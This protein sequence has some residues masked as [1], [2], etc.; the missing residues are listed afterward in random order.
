MLWS[1]PGMM[2]SQSEPL[3]VQRMPWSMAWHCPPARVFTALTSDGQLLGS[4]D[5][6]SLLVQLIACLVSL[7]AP[8]LSACFSAVVAL[9][10]VVGQLVAVVG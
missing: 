5:R 10:V 6:R 4:L 8:I 3:T 2:W 9:V 1:S 7:G